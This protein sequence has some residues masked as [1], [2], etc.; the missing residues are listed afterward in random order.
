MRARREGGKDGRTEKGSYGSN[1]EKRG[2]LGVALCV[3]SVI[4]GRPSKGA[5][6][7]RRGHGALAAIWQLHA[8]AE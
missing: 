3:N 6:R 2:V 5:L 8:A 7:P 1:V 4:A